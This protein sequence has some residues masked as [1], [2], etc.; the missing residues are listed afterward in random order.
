MSSR[1]A[2]RTSRQSQGR[3]R[4][5]NDHTDVQNKAP[6]KRA[7]SQRAP[8]RR[9]VGHRNTKPKRGRP[10]SDSRHSEANTPSTS[11]TT[12]TRRSHDDNVIHSPYVQPYYYEY[13]DENGEIHTVYNG[14]VPIDRPVR[15]VFYDVQ[16]S[17][18]DLPDIHVRPPSQYMLN[19][20]SEN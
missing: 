13:V 7:A 4:P 6:N 9:P 14:D 8:I 5:T 11:Y 18:D 1:F 19:T 20:Q 10:R 16:S 15:R 12:P 17:D 2:Q 3:G